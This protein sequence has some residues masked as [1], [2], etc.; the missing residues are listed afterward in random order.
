[1]GHVDLRPENAL[2]VGEISPAHLLEER[3][4]LLHGGVPVWRIRARFREGA[5]IF[6]DRLG[7][8][9]VHVG[10]AGPDQLQSPFVEPGEVVRR[11]GELRPGCPEPRHVAFDGLHVFRLFLRGVRVVEAEVAFSAEPFRQAEVETDGFGVADVQVSVRFRRKA[12]D[13]LRH[14]SGGKVIGDDALQ[15]VRLPGDACVKQAVRASFCVSHI[16]GNFGGRAAPPFHTP[17][18]GN[19]SCREW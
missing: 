3:Q 13:D 18:P 1:M 9:E 19:R 15:K 12:G 4:V 10:L 17:S 8:L 16:H 6:P 2:A 5:P 7:S 11:V 14:S